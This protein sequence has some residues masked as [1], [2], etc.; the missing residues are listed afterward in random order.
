MDLGIIR[1]LGRWTDYVFKTIGL[2]P[3]APPPPPPPPLSPPTNSL[4]SG[5]I[6]SSGARN[7]VRCAGLSGTLAICLG[8]YGAHAMKDNTSEELRRLFQM[9]QTYHLLHSVAL[10]GLPLVSRPLITGSLFI[11]GIT[12]FCG[13]MY[14]HSIRNDAR[15]RRVTPYGGLL[16]LAGWISIVLL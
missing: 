10:L 2:K 15:Y 3:I 4:M 9:A 5:S 1:D 8:V 11:G 14:F 6:L 16:L 12:L 7:F 13:P